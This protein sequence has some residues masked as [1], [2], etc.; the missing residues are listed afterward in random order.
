MNSQFAKLS[1]EIELRELS[2]DKNDLSIVSLQ[3]MVILIEHSY[4]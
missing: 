4:S 3:I 2:K 1:K